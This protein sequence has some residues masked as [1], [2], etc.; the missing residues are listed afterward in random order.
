MKLYLFGNGNLSFED[1]RTH[2]VRNLDLGTQADDSFVVC[3]FRGA[4]TLVMEYLK[5]HSGRVQV[6]HM[7]ERPRYLPDKYR[8]KVSQWELVGGFESDE[9]RDDAAID[10]S[11]HF[12]AYDTNS[13]PKRQSGT[14]RNIDRCLKLG[15][16]RLEAKER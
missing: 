4:D 15:K 7:G 14:G 12:L 8:T 3:D 11:T 10:A 13:S 9:A 16:I 5:H 6:F 2:Y 1:F